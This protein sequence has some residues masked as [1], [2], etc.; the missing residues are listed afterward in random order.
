LAAEPERLLALAEI[1]GGRDVTGEVT[2]VFA[3]RLTGEATKRPV[4]NWLALV[5]VLLLPLDI[6]A[7]RLVIS[8]RD[9]ERAW[10]AT[11]G[12]L[13][14]ATAQPQPQTEQVSRLF[15]AKQRAMEERTAVADE[16]K[17]PPP[18]GVDKEERRGET[19]VAPPKPPPAPPPS[20]DGSLA[21]R[22]LDKKRHQPRDGQ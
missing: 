1:G 7:R 19:A 18:V 12:R 11:F 22:L 20:G 9:W 16:V 3:D 15:A 2:A 10:A 6:A 4:W 14:P 13:R 5:A 21:S 8:R 17:P